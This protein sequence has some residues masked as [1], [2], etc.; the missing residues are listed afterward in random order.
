MGKGLQGQSG[1]A[2]PAESAAPAIAAM[3]VLP[4]RDRHLYSLVV[5]LAA[6]D[7]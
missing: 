4:R 1:T 5:C 7:H 6:V 2:L 3:H